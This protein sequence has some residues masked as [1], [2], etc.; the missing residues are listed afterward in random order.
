MS[1]KWATP[2]QQEQYESF[3][4]DPQVI[5]K[6]KDSAVIK[7]PTTENLQL[8]L[9]EGDTHSHNQSPKKAISE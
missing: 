8:A 5:R 6:S 1:N 7:F 4:K 9:S 2:K 3:P